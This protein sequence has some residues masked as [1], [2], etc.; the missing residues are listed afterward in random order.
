MSVTDCE[1]YQLK[2]ELKEKLKAFKGNTVRSKG[3]TKH[4]NFTESFTVRKPR[5]F[6]DRG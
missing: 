4:H 6:I 5:I 2:S 1:T 3:G